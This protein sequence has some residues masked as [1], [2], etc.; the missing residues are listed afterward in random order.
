MLEYNNLL[1][2]EYFG[3]VELSSIVYQ[4]DEEEKLQTAG[5]NFNTMILWFL[6][7]NTMILILWQDY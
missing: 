3:P 1:Q 2:G 6:W 7:F 4:L 5:V